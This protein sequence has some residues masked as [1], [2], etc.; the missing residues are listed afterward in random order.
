[1]RLIDLVVPICADE[2]KMLQLGLFEHIL[3]QVERV[4]IEPLESVEEQ[5]ERMVWAREDAHEPAK[6]QLEADPG[7]VRRDIGNSRLFS[8]DE[9][10]RGDEVRHERAIRVKGPTKLASPRIQFGLGLA[11]ELTNESLERQCHGGVRNVAFELVD[12]AGCEQP[13]CRN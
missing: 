2:E 8:D 9:P 4:G 7:G 5:N 3:E 12:L 13:S 1:M 11:Q 6:R 10:Q